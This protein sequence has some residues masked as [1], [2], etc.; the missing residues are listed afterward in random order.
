MK[1]AIIT[2]QHF[3]VRN[4][5]EAFQRYFR[6]FYENCFFKTLEDRGIKTVI[7]MGDITDRRKYI[8]FKTLNFLRELY[9]E[10]LERMGVVQ[11]NI[12]G[13]HDC[14][15][16]NTNRVNSMTELFAGKRIEN[17]HVYDEPT[18]LELD[19]LK[20]MFIPWINDENKQRTLDMIQT[21]DAKIAMGH[22]ELAGF[23]MYLGSVMPH[24]MDRNVFDRFDMVFTGHYHHKS[25][26]G[27]I[28]YLGAPCEYTWS[29]YN[30][31]RGFHI[32]D[33]DTL[34]LEYVQNPFRI[35]RKVYYDDRGLTQIQRQKLLHEFK[36]TVDQYKDCF[37]RVMVR[38]KE[39]QRTFEQ[40]LDLLYAAQPVDVSI[41]E[42]AT[43]TLEIQ[44]ADV[45][46]S[47]DTLTILHKHIDSLSTVPED[48]KKNLKL[49][50]DD[51]YR[52]ALE[53]EDA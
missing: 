45:D 5:S 20:V 33:T 46:L 13:N 39:D 31:P 9:I 11:H 12:I 43:L 50:M 48:D 1:V 17:F 37:V 49:L 27:K 34:E 23:Q 15:Y 29:D 14:F 41:T 6:N 2:D 3:G 36:S 21:T 28:Y 24:G 7:N 52:K 38:G 19:G 4:D 25:D 16:K 35:F 51:M 47:E 22:L 44:A 18:E 42:D 32:F 8:N 10:R 30:D 53:L 26:D 40:M